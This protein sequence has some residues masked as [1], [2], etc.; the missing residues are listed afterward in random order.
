MFGEIVRYKCR[1]Q[2][3]GIGGDGPRFSEGVWLG[4]DRRTTQNVIFDP[5]NGGIRHA[6]TIMSL[7]NPQKVDVDR[8][9]AVNVTPGLLHQPVAEPPVMDPK[10]AA[11]TPA[12][13]S[14][15][16][17]RNVYIRQEDLERFGYSRNCR[18]CSS[19]QLYGKGAGTMPHSASCRERIVGEL[20]NTPKGAE[21]VRRMTEKQDR[22]SAEELARDQAEGAQGA[23]T[24]GNG[25]PQH[26]RQEA[27][28]A[29][30]QGLLPPAA[31]PG[32][33][34]DH[35]VDDR[36]VLR[37]RPRTTERSTGYDPLA[38]VR[39]T[40]EEHRDDVDYSIP[41]PPDSLRPDAIGQETMGANGGREHQDVTARY[42]YEAGMDIDVV[43]SKSATSLT[44][45][46]GSNSVPA[47][48]RV[49]ATQL[50]QA[51][52]EDDDI[53]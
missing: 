42:P 26:D 41:L 16:V 21:R 39:P 2:E 44:P 49:C 9:A 46:A 53:D 1:S 13:D 27:Q 24:D 34:L 4:F 28:E 33:A 14:V 25:P 31:A 51:W 32:A 6:R 36:P 8:V 18:K 40:R 45:V 52:T 22:Y 29:L 10:E 37:L 20:M 15:P 5:D 47:T 23:E 7:P 17:A 12:T 19:I 35:H 30:A 3:G 11:P 43:H 38:H 48:D 50:A